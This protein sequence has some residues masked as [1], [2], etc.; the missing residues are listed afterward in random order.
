M[1]ST[2]WFTNIVIAFFTSLTFAGMLISLEQSMEISLPFVVAYLSIVAITCFAFRA[3]FRFIN[4]T[5][6][7]EWKIYFE[8]LN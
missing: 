8:C 1:T 2:K 3:I 5:T 7:G 6:T 4:G